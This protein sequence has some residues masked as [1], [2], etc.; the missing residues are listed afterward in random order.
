MEEFAEVV[1]ISVSTV[2]RWEKS[3]GKL[4]PHARPH[5]RLEHLADIRDE[6][7]EGRFEGVPGS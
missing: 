6:I 1:E 7:L 3:K 2:F 4:K 5:R